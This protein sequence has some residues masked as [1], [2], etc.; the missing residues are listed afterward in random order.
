MKIHKD[1]LNRTFSTIEKYGV[2]E[3]ILNSDSKLSDLLILNLSYKNA[4][5]FVVDTEGKYVA[6]I[7]HKSL[8]QNNTENLFHAD[9]LLGEICESHGY[10]LSLSFEND[11]LHSLSP[12]I[13]GFFKLNPHEFECPLVDDEGVLIGIINK[14]YYHAEMP[15]GEALLSKG[16]KYLTYN[17]DY[18]IIPNTAGLNS[19]KRTVFSQWGEDGILEQIFNTI[20]FTSKYVVE[21]GGGDGVY[22]SNIRNLILNHGC[23]G[24]FIEGDPVK[25]QK[26]AETYADNP[27]IVS[28]CDYVG[29]ESNTKLDDILEANNAPAEIDFCSIDIDGYD[30]FVWEAFVKYRP[31]VIAIEI[32]PSIPNDVLFIQPR[33]E[34]VF[35]G[36]SAAAMVLLGVKKGYELVAVTETNCIFVLKELF[37]RFNI[38]DNSLNALHNEEGWSNGR[39]F[40]MYDKTLYYS[41]CN[42]FIWSGGEKFGSDKLLMMKQQSKL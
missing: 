42:W 37:D 26:C 5:F 3:R 33:S 27:D 20:G 23:R 2:K 35:Q 11:K 39:Y 22:L 12:D 1:I 19:F 16:H 34:N 6:T 14:L 17:Y 32:N 21:F 36:S 40:Q 7:T 9:T 41:G 4:Y 24:I 38:L 15:V 18:S 29:F 8:T 10:N 25:S 30:Y 13:Y 28:V 31:R